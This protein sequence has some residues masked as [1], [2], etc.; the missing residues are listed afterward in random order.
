MIDRVVIVPRSVITDVVFPGGKVVTYR[1][2]ERDRL[3]RE[4]EI[5]RERES[6]R[7]VIEAEV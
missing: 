6:F 4:R 1:S 7:R 3:E 5:E 2:Y